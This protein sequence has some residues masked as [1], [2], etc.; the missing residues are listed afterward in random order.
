VE[1]VGTVAGDEIMCVLPGFDGRIASVRRVVDET[2]C[3]P[4]AIDLS[5]VVRHA[6]LL[7][8][9]HWQQGVE[10]ARRLGRGQGLERGPLTNEKL[11]DLVGVRLPLPGEAL[12]PPLGGGIRNGQPSGPARII[13]KRTRLDNQRFDLACIIAA[14][15]VLPTDQHLFPRH[16]RHPSLQKLQRAFAQEL[17]YPWENLDAYTDEHGLDEPL[18]DA[19]EH[20]VVS[21][22]VVRSALANRGK[23][24]RDRLP[25]A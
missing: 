21:E 4:T 9:L 17:L 16:D 1:E 13:T 24:R 18:M 23:M 12:R 7:G 25:L 19:A 10:L 3:S 15:H 5:W 20:F 8:G 6:I 14:A 2:M 11:S 22:W